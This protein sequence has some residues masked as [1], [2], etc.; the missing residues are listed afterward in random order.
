MGM[1]QQPKTS[2]LASAAGISMSYASQIVNSN[3]TPSRPLAIHI[4]R[5]TGWRH[6][7]LTDL[8]DEHIAM[9]EQ[10]EPWQ[11]KERAA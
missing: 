1:E 8:S 11:G 4:M 2:D 5:T 9:L 7:V 10:I 3:R 6:P